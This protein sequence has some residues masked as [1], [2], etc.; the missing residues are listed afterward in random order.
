[1]PQIFVAGAHIGGYDDLCLLDMSGDLAEMLG[2]KE[3]R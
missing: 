2:T 1:V 3:N